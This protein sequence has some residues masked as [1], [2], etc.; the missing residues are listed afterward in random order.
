MNIK[1]KFFGELT[2][3]EERIIEFPNGLPGFEDEKRFVLLNI[4]ESGTYQSLQS[5]DREEV[6]LVVTNPYLFFSDYEFHLDTNTLELLNINRQE[7][8]SIITVLTLEEPFHNTTANLQAP[9][10][11]HVNEQIAKQIILMD[12]SYSTKHHI[13]TNEKGGESHA[14]SEP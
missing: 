9:I 4:D 14:H 10:I 3:E 1:T 7:D 8:V 13:M 6:A 11:L 2:I 5:V 12:T